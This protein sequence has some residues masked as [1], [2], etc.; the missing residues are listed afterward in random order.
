M[1][2]RIGQAADLQPLGKLFDLLLAYGHQ[3]LVALVDV[4][5]AAAEKD[6]QRLAR[7]VA[8]GDGGASLGRALTADIGGDLVLALG[9]S[10]DQVLAVHHTEGDVTR[11]VLG[12]ESEDAL[13]R[14]VLRDELTHPED[15]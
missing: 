8:G 6:G 15:A 7:R 2:A 5:F 4:A 1:L 3:H 11:L 10:L 14:L 12:S 9:L 13:V